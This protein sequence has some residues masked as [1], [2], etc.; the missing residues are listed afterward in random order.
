MKLKIINEIKNPLFPRTEVKAE[1]E[2]EVVPTKDEVADLLVA[3]YKA[4][5]EAIK[6]MTVEGKFGMRIFEVDAHIYSSIDDKNRIETKTKQE[7]ESEKKIKED[8][9][10]VAAEERKAKEDAE[11]AAAE[12]K[13]SEA[14]KTEE[15]EPIAQAPIEEQAKPESESV[16]NT[17]TEEVKE[18][19]KE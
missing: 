8:A 15:A 7:K 11:K 5:K 19:A 1:V 9:E 4:D 13:V 17:P 14:P 12:A 3:K 18:E 6:V 2:N 16:E 10:K